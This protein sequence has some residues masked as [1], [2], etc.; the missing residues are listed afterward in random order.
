MGITYAHGYVSPTQLYNELNNAFACVL[1]LDIRGI[2]T[3]ESHIDFSVL[4]DIRNSASKIAE[5]ISKAVDDQKLIDVHLVL[6][7]D[8]L[9]K[10]Y[11]LPH[12]IDKAI[13]IHNK[14]ATQKRRITKKSILIG[15]FQSFLNKWPF[16][17][18][19]N[20]KFEHG[21]IY[22]NCVFESQ[23]QYGKPLRVFISGYGM[24][25]DPVIYDPL[26]INSVVNVTPEVPFVDLKDADKDKALRKFRI[27]IIDEPEQG[28]KLVEMLDEAFDFINQG[29]HLDVKKFKGHQK[30]TVGDETRGKTMRATKNV[31]LGVLVHCKHGQS[32]SVAVVTAWM[33]HMWNMNY[34]EA[35][36]AI[37]TARP[38]ARTKFKE[39]VEGWVSSK[40]RVK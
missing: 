27:A 37:K 17:C 25:C 14:Q 20:S 28:G 19:K 1:T 21:R 32:R 15:G 4:I 12:I 24:A 40:Q 35:S 29:L 2:S 5:Q 22:P 18:S 9:R 36:Q 7:S 16:M 23:G 34:Q 6:V 10:L 30:T 11:K 31:P 3:E 38:K 8:G 13:Y 33:M 26:C 39:H